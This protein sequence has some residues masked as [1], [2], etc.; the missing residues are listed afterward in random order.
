ME[1]LEIKQTIEQQP[2][3]QQPTEK[4]RQHTVYLLCPKKN[5]SLTTTKSCTECESYR[6]LSLNTAIPTLV[7]EFN[8]QRNLYLYANCTK[9]PKPKFRRVSTLCQNCEKFRG[10]DETNHVRCA[11]TRKKPN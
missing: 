7:C 8:K 9:D 6:G 5:H 3:I 2:K 4:I 1:K 11:K 10:I